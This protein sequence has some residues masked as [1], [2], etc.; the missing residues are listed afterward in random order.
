MFAK[1]STIER[2]TVAE[3]VAETL[4]TRILAGELSEGEQLRQEVLA[5]DL[6]VSR[7]PLREAFRLLEG[8]GLITIAP[9]RGAVVA[10]RSPEEIGE[11]FDLRVLLEPDILRH[12][13]PKLTERD[14][15][16]AAVILD[17]YNR[18]LA[19]RDVQAWGRLNT[20]FHLALYG[21]AARPRS[22]A[23]VRSLLDQTDSYTR[24]QLLLTGGQQRAEREH[25]EL[26]KL[27]RARETNAAAK[28]VEDHVR[29]A[30]RSLV[31]FMHKQAAA[32][33]KS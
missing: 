22:L 3:S 23:L 1:R 7:I 20:Q 27:C 16:E 32:K 10:V 2:K 6:G 30:G 15:S 12:A 26:L 14:L 8:E 24:M 4:R 9:H 5:A 13:V 33:K 18:A 31:D 11:L 29:E 25:T 19:E 28:L 17:G 21:P